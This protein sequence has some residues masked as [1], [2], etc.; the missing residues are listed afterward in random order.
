MHS[1]P[2]RLRASRD[3]IWDANIT[4]LVRAQ[5]ARNEDANISEFRFKRNKPRKRANICTRV[6]RACKYWRVLWGL[7]LTDFGKLSN[8][9][10]INF[11]WNEDSI[12]MKQTKHI[13]KVP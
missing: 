11:L 4:F 7:F 1:R 5:V 12:E 6:V 10:G 9:L 8:S 13:E 2:C 3:K